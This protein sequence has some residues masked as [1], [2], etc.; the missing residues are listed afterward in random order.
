MAY[1]SVFGPKSIGHYS[2]VFGPAGI[3][4][5]QNPERAVWGE[6]ARLTAAGLPVP[7]E[8]KPHNL[9]LTAL[10]W[11]GRP[12]KAVTSGIYHG[13][14]S[15]SLGGALGGFVGGLTGTERHGTRDILQGL[16]VQNKAALAVGG[17]VGDVALDPVTYTGLGA[18]IKLGKF[19]KPAA[20]AAMVQELGLKA[21]AR[22]SRDALLGRTA[23]A[24]TERVGALKNLI[25]VESWA[26]P[27][28]AKSM[29][30]Q[31]RVFSDE[32]GFFAQKASELGRTTT[33]DTI[34]QGLIGRMA[35]ADPALQQRILSMSDDAAFMADTLS[36]AFRSGIKHTD[37]LTTAER[38]TSDTFTK[39]MLPGLTNKLGT[40]RKAVE[41]VEFTNGL[42]ADFDREAGKT[43]LY[44]AG[45]PVMDVTRVAKAP[46]NM[47]KA[48]YAN[49]PVV[50]DLVDAVGGLF[51][52]HYIKWSTLAS[53]AGPAIQKAEGE[54]TD[55]LR[56]SA[57]I[58][59]MSAKQVL[60]LFGEDLGPKLAGSDKIRK[61]TF[62]YVER[63]IDPMA[64]Q[65]WQNIARTLTADELRLVDDI[66]AQHNLVMQYVEGLD[67]AAGL[68]YESI[69]NYA[70]HYYKHPTRKAME[71]L[72]AE[73]LK[74]KAARMASQTTK[75]HPS[76]FG[77]DLP[78]AA[79][80]KSVGLQPVDD[81]LLA[82]AIRLTRSQQSLLRKDF[83]DSLK[84]LGK[85]AVKTSPAP[86]YISTGVRGLENQYVHP[87]VA[88]HLARID[89]VFVND[90]ET[91][92]FL[93]Y[94]DTLTN[95]WKGTVTAMNP[96]FH[97]R[98][99]MGEGLMNFM[100]GVA[101]EVHAEA[102][103]LLTGQADSV[104]IN[105]TTVTK[106][107]LMDVYYEAGL[108]FSG[109]TRGNY[110]Q[111][112]QD[113]VREAVQEAGWTRKTL[114]ASTF[115]PQN[116]GREVGDFTETW[117]RLS[118]F[119]DRL[120][121]G[122]SWK[123][124]AADVRKFHVDYKELTVAER[125]IFRRLAPFYT[126][127]RNNTPMQLRLLVESPGWFTAV[128]KAI[129]ASRFALSNPEMPS[130]MTENLA[131]PI[132]RYPDGNFIVLNWN[133]PM[134]DLGRFHT[135]WREMGKEAVSM[136]HPAL[137]NPFELLANK[138][139]ATGM[140]IEKFP[141]ERVPLFGGVGPK[142]PA[143]AAYLIGQLG[144]FGQARQA[145][146]MSA[147]SRTATGP[148]RP[149]SYMSIFLP[150]RIEN[151]AQVHATRMYAY[152]DQ[153]QNEIMRRQGEGYQIP[154]LQSLRSGRY[155]P[156]FGGAGYTP[157]FGYQPIF[158]GGRQTPQR[159]ITTP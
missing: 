76:V 94:F 8:R 151:P 33:G 73:V 81:L 105:G 144:A 46:V 30:K 26:A 72:E 158:G 74:S 15:E 129:E 49:H 115:M 118:H 89:R 100:A 50:Q 65:E 148:T 42:V 114:Q 24:A 11:L 55:F 63:M 1:Q 43:F 48:A 2:P 122:L 107:M 104:V 69:P 14:E 61:A 38:V 31:G 110:I 156:I 4:P 99:L 16:G 21:G 130:Y 25:P 125:N 111:S 96:A 41:R 44:F 52:P 9:L 85:D 54:I 102:F 123:E 108:G 28:I 139:L 117:F 143:T 75:V 121:K 131:I 84:A 20:S 136:V 82:D 146:K 91:N 116:V 103:K 70:M 62:Y 5:K 18:G 142:V 34:R 35:A 19:A 79:F 40:Y 58:P 150:T 78:S 140:P 77:R 23:Q 106:K 39:K 134:T 157:V 12:Q 135:E 154:P 153:L 137:K 64:D 53:K 71:N 87:E 7:E 45:K 90:V 92:Q 83:V 141:G 29:R 86:G 17:F 3:V 51:G 56:R 93:R 66:A 126:Y 112:M 145:L 120:D 149:A 59:Q 36:G 47:L 6:Q 159:I 152:R 147:E 68:E 138:N 67:K 57:G 97:L 113:M 155:T 119:I 128:G 80:A 22:V 132:Y 124:A 98:N 133:L 60:D 95:L 27:G 37:I 127:M 10:D 88:R 109:M 101:P 13:L 32:L